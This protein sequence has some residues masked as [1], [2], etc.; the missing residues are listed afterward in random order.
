[1]KTALKVEKAWDD[2]LADVRKD[3]ANHT[4]L[5]AASIAAADW[6]SKQTD[7]SRTPVLDQ[8][9]RALLNSSGRTK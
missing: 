2:S 7:P 6:I 3:M 8:L 4:Q 1:M 5:L 9:L